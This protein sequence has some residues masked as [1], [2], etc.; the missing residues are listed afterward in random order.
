[1][2]VPG[3]AQRGSIARGALSS[4]L[5]DLEGL[6]PQAQIHNQVSSVFLL[7]LIRRLKPLD[8]QVILLYPEGETAAAIAEVTGLSAGNVATKIH[9]IKNAL[10]QIYL[11][12]AP[13]AA[14]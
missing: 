5:V 8:R 9:R 1:M 4:R 3:G 10:K 2:G 13:D 7:D 14:I 11:E 6:E 12:G